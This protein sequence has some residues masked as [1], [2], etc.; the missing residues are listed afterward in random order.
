MSTPTPAPSLARPARSPLRELLTI[1]APV[2]ATML[3][4]TLAQFVDAAM[5]ARLGPRAL[6]AQGNGSIMAF[7]PIAACLGIVTIINTFVSQHLGAGQ[8]RKAPAYAWNGLWL[9][10]L[11]WIAIFIPLGLLTSPIT[12]IVLAGVERLTASA[13][14][15]AD[16]GALSFPPEVV[17]MQVDYARILLLGAIFMIGARAISQFFFGL[18]APVT[19]LVA[20]VVGNTVNVFANYVLIFGNFGA[21]ALGVEGAAIGTV[22]GAAVEMSIPMAIFLGPKLNRRYATRA[23]WRP[24]LARQKDL[25]RVGWP[26]GLMFGNE[27]VCWYLLLGVLIAGISEAD[28]AAGWIGL[29]YMQLS[30]MPTVGLSI[31][32]TAVVGKYMGM[33][34]PDLARHRTWL[35]L[36]VA[37]VYMG[38]CA[39]VFLIFR[40]PLVRAFVNADEAPA[41]ASEVVRIGSAV[42]VCAAVFQLFDACGITL[43]GALRGAGDTVWP[44]VMTA[45]LSWTILIGGGWTMISLFPGLRSIGPWIAASVYI[46]IFAG[47]MMWR[48]L[49]GRWREIQL[50]E[51]GPLIP[52]VGAGDFIGEPGLLGGVSREEYD[53]EAREAAAAASA[54]VERQTPAP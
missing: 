23:A 34:R 43:A 52:D 26:A 15:G 5:V 31:A 16:G 38:A 49:S 17:A 53:A 30:F 33:G 42:M 24:S 48:F 45:L 14:D 37:M 44:G 3:S 13:A 10:A 8:E 9:C 29:R 4:Y 39:A 40:E 28:N 25:I 6:A 36:R 7:V 2:A 18:H 51:R 19:V 32:V 27:V 35:G 21:P 46:I 50:I 20:T 11:F 12:D 54:D 1:A 41:M 22:I 47:A